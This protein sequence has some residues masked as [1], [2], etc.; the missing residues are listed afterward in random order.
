[1]SFAFPVRAFLDIHDFGVTDG[2]DKDTVVND[3][4]KDQALVG[5][6][7][8]SIGSVG[9]AY[10][11]ELHLTSPSIDEDT[12]N[13]E[14][15]SFSVAFGVNDGSSVG[16][17]V[18]QAGMEC[19]N[20]EYLGAFKTTWSSGGGPGTMSFLPTGLGLP[21]LAADIARTTSTFTA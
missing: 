8:D 10:V 5:F 19:L 12:L 17:I 21:G 3:V 14:S 20:G 4:Y 7:G 13:T 6:K 9:E 11:F 18:G 16:T 15:G 2:S 1:G